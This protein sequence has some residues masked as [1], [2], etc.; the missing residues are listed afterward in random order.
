MASAAVNNITAAN[1]AAGAAAANAP[2]RLFPPKRKDNISTMI[3]N[4]PKCGS[5]PGL[6][7]VQHSS[8]KLVELQAKMVYDFKFF[9]REDNNADPTDDMVINEMNRLYHRLKSANAFG[10]VT[11]IDEIIYEGVWE[12]NL[13]NNE[14]GLQWIANRTRISNMYVLNSLGTK[15]AVCRTCF[16][17]YR[18]MVRFDVGCP[19]IDVYT[20]SARDI[21]W[22]INNTG[23]LPGNDP[24][25]AIPA[26]PAEV[27]ANRLDV[28]RVLQQIVD[29]RIN[30][31]TP[32]APLPPRP[33]INNIPVDVPGR[34][35]AGSA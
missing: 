32:I 10:N 17:D 27:A 24:R 16:I 22:A 13:K 11:N 30:T 5:H 7:I 19:A 28:I 8:K 2:I 29:P 18:K 4:V 23:E 35:R 26:T 21:V 20:R 31:S 25:V 3:K 14:P 34:R 6:Q 12:H 33:V 15:I 1:M 9:Y